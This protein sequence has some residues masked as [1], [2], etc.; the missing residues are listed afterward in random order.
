MP[1]DHTLLDSFSLDGEWGLPGSGRSSW[2]HGRAEY[3][4]DRG[5]RLALDGLLEKLPKRIPDEKPAHHDAVVGESSNGDPITLLD[6]SA[7]RLVGLN[8]SQI[9][10][11]VLRRSYNARW[12]IVGEL[13]SSFAEMNCRTVSVRYYNLEEWIGLSG[14]DRDL[15]DS[16][17]TIRFVKP[18]PIVFSLGPFEITAD[19][20]VASASDDFRSLDISQRARIAAQVE[21]EQ[22]L[23]EFLNGPIT[24]IRY[25]AQLAVGHRLPILTLNAESSR[26]V[27]IVGGKARSRLVQV[28]FAQSRPLPKPRQM[29]PTEMVFTLAALADNLPAYVSGWHDGFRKFRAALDSYFSLDPELDADVSLEHHF[30]SVINAFEIYHRIGSASQFEMPESQHQTRITAI[31]ESVPVEFRDWLHRR[32]EYSNEVPLRARLA[33]LY[34]EQPESVLHLLGTKKRFCAR[35]TNTRNYL[36]H[37]SEKLRKASMSGFDLWL[38]TKQLRIALQVSLFRRLG[39]TGEFIS[40]AM[41]RTAEYRTLSAHAKRASQDD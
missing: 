3:T 5:T 21:Q 19:Y 35:M 16:G 23:A 4:P 1:I 36:T 40:Q 25:M 12:M 14:L 8:T 2:I 17:I 39:L 27:S 37:R 13:L 38:G 31:V 18:T 10:G 15:T 11:F 22:H 6:V 28:F 26:T 32:L 30:L 24:S 7:N 20:V 33:E 34:E 41:T 29:H 9:S